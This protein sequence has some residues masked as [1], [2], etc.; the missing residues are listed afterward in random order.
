MKTSDF[1]YDLPK[2][3]IAQSPVSP[4]DKCKLMILDRKKRE[5]IEKKFYEIVDFL[6]SGDVLV[7]NDTKVIPARIKCMVNGKEVEIFLTRQINDRDWYAIGKPGK[8]LRKGN[9]IE[10]SDDL[11][12]EII[13]VLDDGRRLIR[14]SK[15]GEELER[16][17]DEVGSP[18]Y[19]PYIKNE[20]ISFEEYQTVYAS[21]KG[22]VAAPTAG[23]HFTENLMNRLRRNGI[24]I[25]FVTLHV[26]LGTFMPIKTDDVKNHKMHTEFYELKKETANRLNGARNEGRRIIAV[27]TTSVR[28]L[29]STCRKNVFC[30]GLGETDMFIYPG[31]KWK[32]VDGLITNFHL[33]KS[34]LLLLTCAFG[35]REFVLEAYEEAKSKRYRFY[36]FGDAMLIL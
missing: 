29:E 26:G 27:G 34:S 21:R 6:K 19:P 10:I 12:L 18:P 17:I 24:Q 31:Y 2:N 1:N 3:L 13:D 11:G 30:P 33:P 35:G 23:L 16:I 25:E 9:R 7:F 20:N 36:S 14:F 32:C 22:S 28:V 15:S 5:I 8:I 4:R